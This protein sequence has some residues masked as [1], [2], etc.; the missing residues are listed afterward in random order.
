MTVFQKTMHCP[1]T[2][3]IKINRTNKACFAYLHLASN[4]TNWN[5][6]PVRTQNLLHHPVKCVL[7]RLCGWKGE[8]MNR[9]LNENKT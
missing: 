2:G 7:I 6:F 8:Q 4:F 1:T 3:T 5:N 9:W